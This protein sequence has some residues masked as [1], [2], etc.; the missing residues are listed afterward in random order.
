MA[1][2]TVPWGIPLFDDNTPFAPIQAPFNSQSAA[3]NDALI[4]AM[5][6][7]NVF[8]RYATKALM[9]AAPGTVG[10]E[11]ATVFSDP[12]SS[13]NG[14][15]YWTSGGWVV[16]LPSSRTFALAAN[17]GGT[18][19]SQSSTETAGLVVT[20]FS[21]NRTT[22]ASPSTALISVPSDFR[23]AAGLWY[24]SGIGRTTGGMAVFNVDPAG[25]CRIYGATTAQVY[26]GTI[27]WRI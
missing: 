18:M 16:N 6:G 5:S 15:Y 13:N 19:I 21:I 1:D 7:P 12:D 3:L 24:G 9:D 11:H 25:T 23:P 22:A 2:P 4:S 20:T 26:D 17:G 14:D 8:K 27:T 10:R